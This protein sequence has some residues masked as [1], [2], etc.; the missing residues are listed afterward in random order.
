[1]R[2]ADCLSNPAVDTRGAMVPRPPVRVRERPS[3]EHDGR[4]GATCV[5]QHNVSGPN[6]K[7]MS[8]AEQLSGR[9]ACLHETVR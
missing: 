9:G 8:A 6:G 3:A 7:D 5:M 2:Y 1:M 4:R